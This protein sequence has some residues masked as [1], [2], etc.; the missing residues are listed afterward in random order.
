[1][2][3]ANLERLKCT[4]V[5]SGDFVYNEDLKIC[6]L[7]CIGCNDDRVRTG[8]PIS[9]ILVDVYDPDII[10]N[11]VRI[12]G[13]PLSK[14]TFDTIEDCVYVQEATISGENSSMFII[15]NFIF[16]L[17]NTSCMIFDKSNEFVTE[18]KYLHELQHILH[19]INVDFKLN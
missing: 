18:I 19:L 5:M 10:I 12:Y 14:V 4:D 9:H 16:A 11:D 1:M 2:R 13:I 3:P 17:S 6:E 8:I 7:L 15:K